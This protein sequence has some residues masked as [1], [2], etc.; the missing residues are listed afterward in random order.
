MAAV[1]IEE[2]TLQEI[3]NALRVAT[4]FFIA[5]DEMN[6]HVHLAD[7]RYSPITEMSAQA[8]ENALA[9]FSD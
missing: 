4:E 5:R 9:V 6:S 7:V 8:H 1:L 3:V 2:D